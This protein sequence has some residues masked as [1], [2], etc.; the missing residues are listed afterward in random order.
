MTP[1]EKREKE[2]ERGREYRSR[3]E[4]RDRL[5]EYRARPEVKEQAREYLEKYA[6]EYK[7]RPG[8]M[9]RRRQ[10]VREYKSRPENKERL[11]EINNAYTRARRLDPLVYLRSLI[12]DAKKRAK[13]EGLPFDLTAA[14][15]VVPE[16]CPVL[17]IPLVRGDKVLGDS[18]PSLDRITPTLGYVR[19]NVAVISYRANRIKQNATPDELL[20]V[21]EWARRETLRVKGAA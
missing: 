15:I 14:D 1:E 10:Y 12:A 18:S 11:R 7:S 2:R 20:A 17:G 16:L 21:A 8:V 9:E 4:V 3:P 6:P 19:G 13:R 5:R